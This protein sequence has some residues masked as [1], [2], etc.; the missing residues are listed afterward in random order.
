M[1]AAGSGSRID[2][3]STPSRSLTLESGRRNVLA[4]VFVGGLSFAALLAGCSTTDQADEISDLS[5]AVVASSELL[6]G[7]PVEGVQHAYV[8][9]E[10]AAAVWFKADPN[11]DAFVFAQVDESLTA[12][13]SAPGPL[14]VTTTVTIR[15]DGTLYEAISSPEAPG[16]WSSTTP[17]HDLPLALGLVRISPDGRV[18]DHISEDVSVS[19]T[20]SAREIVW[21]LREPFR[22][23]EAVQQWRIGSDGLLRAWSTELVG[24][25]LPYSGPGGPYDTVVVEYWPRGHLAIE[26]P[27]VDDEVDLSLLEPP[28]GFPRGLSEAGS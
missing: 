7:S 12:D 22:D 24:I 2:H 1:V 14:G 3:R 23:G 4:F 13:F 11:G 15:L 17:A 10:L 5:E 25:S 21:E 19:R 6:A 9:G 27:T 18:V 20:E 8:D 26:P 16:L 28:A